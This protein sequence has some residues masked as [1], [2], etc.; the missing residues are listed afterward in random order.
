MFRE[1]QGLGKQETGIKQPL[2]VQLKQDKVGIGLDLLERERAQLKLKYS[3]HMSDTFV[4]N[5]KFD[6]LLKYVLSLYSL[7]IGN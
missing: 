7:Y 1:G 6:F 4:N 3:Q 5:R 2:G